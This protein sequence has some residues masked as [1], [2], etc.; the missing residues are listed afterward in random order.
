MGISEI[1]DFKA[2]KS[3]RKASDYWVA[4]G[5][6]RK[7]VGLDGWLRVGLLTDYP[8]RFE[9]GSKIYIQKRLAEPTAVIVDDWR[10]HF[11]ETTLEIKIQ[12]AEDIDAAAAYVNAMIVIPKTERKELNSDWDFYPDELDGMKVL[13]PEGTEV[14]SIVKLETEVP[15]PY[16]IIKTELEGNEEVMVPF[17]KRFIEKIDR[18]TKTIKLVEP[19][20]F[21]SLGK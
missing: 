7:T 3:A 10:D 15:C 12:G 13:D 2:K 14:G 20:S 21:H 11:H 4:I 6:I 16:F 19:L 1:I 8:E 17:L 5:N 9:P 18:T